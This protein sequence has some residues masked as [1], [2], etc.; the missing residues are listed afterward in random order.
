MKALLLSLGFLVWNISAAQL[1]VLN[2]ST[3]HIQAGTR[4]AV[5]GPLT[6]QLGSDATLINDGVIQ[7]GPEA[8]LIEPVGGPIVGTGVENTTRTF[9][10]AVVDNEPAGL[11]LGMSCTVPI[12]TFTLV[13]GHEPFLLVNGGSGIS[14]WFQLSTNEFPGTLLQTD[15]HYDP[16]ELN[17]LSP[18]SLDLYNSQDPNGFWTPRSGSASV[19]P[20]FVSAELF[21]PWDY[22]SAF[23]SDVT[24]SLAEREGPGFKAWPTLTNGTVHLETF[25]SE[26]IRTWELRDGSGRLFQ[27][28]SHG[29]HG[30]A[31]RTIDISAYATGLY[32]LRVNGT[33]TIKILKQ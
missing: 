32:L 31:Y 2:G 24:T 10:T 5:D 29:E 20:W 28:E 14:R 9:V 27:S 16:S 13:R 7:F 8:T 11:G 25:G 15:L 1:M 18:S 6:W 23:R 33:N 12:G 22:I 26:G 4:L 17:G 30:I 19:D 21:W 3:M